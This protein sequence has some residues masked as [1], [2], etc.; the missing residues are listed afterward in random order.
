MKGNKY[1]FF[2]F[3]EW[4][5]Y[6]SKLEFVTYDDTIP[7]IRWLHLTIFLPLLDSYFALPFRK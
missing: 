7:G 2:K 6:H 1:F 3:H 4:Y 5:R